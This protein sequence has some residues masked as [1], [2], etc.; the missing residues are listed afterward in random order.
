MEELERE[1]N[2]FKEEVQNLK[3]DNRKLKYESKQKVDKF[4][5]ITNDNFEL[6]KKVN[7]LESHLDSLQEK[8]ES[9]EFGIQV[10]GLGNKERSIQ[11]DFDNEEVLNLQNQIEKLKKDKMDEKVVV[12]RIKED[13]RKKYKVLE[14]ELEISY[15]V[16]Y[17]TRLQ[18]LNKQIIEQKQQV[19][20]SKHKTSLQF[21]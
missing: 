8:P 3:D 12:E 16:Q 18:N 20:I 17:K 6:L 21:F 10:V 11:A 15:E 9:N 2:E 7:D 14:N 4:K 13:L 19:L 5:K 1:R